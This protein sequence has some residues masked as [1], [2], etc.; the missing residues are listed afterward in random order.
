MKPALA[1]SGQ[2]ALTSF[3]E[4]LEA[5][6]PFPLLLIDAHMPELDGFRLAELIRSSTKTC[7]TVMVMLISAGQRCDSARCRDLG[8]AAVTK[9]TGEAELLHAISQALGTGSPA[10]TAAAPSELP[11]KQET[12]PLRILVAEDNEVNQQLIVR[13]LE[14][15]KNAVFLAKNGRQALAM[16]ENERFDLI[17]MDLQM[18][19]MDGYEATAVIRNREESTGEHIPIVALTAH[20]MKGHQEACLKAGMDAYISKPIKPQRLFEVIEQV[21]AAPAGI[22]N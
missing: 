3:E 2:A 17:L 4:A 7:D 22:A 13:L 14:R 12:K 8:I 15:R 21:M 1:E 11:P 5:G 20:A 9:P 10:A 6:E 18:P 19:E 16:L